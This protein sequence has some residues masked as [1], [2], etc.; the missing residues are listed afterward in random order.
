MDGAELLA[1][2]VGLFPGSKLGGGTGRRVDEHALHVRK[3]VR[4]TEKEVVARLLGPGLDGASGTG[5]G[6]RTDV[7]DLSILD[8]DHRPAGGRLSTADRATVTPR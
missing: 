4:E 1:Q 3:P 5:A 8:G 6:M 2:G 7:L